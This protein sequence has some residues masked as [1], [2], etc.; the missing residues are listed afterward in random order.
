MDSLKTSSGSGRGRIEMNDKKSEKRLLLDPT[1]QDSVAL[2]KNLT[3]KKSYAALSCIISNKRMKTTDAYENL[4]GKERPVGILFYCLFLVLCPL[5][6]RYA[7]M[8]SVTKE[9]ATPKLKEVGNATLEMF[10]DWSCTPCTSVAG[11]T[12]SSLK[13]RAINVTSPNLEAGFPSIAIFASQD[14]KTWLKSHDFSQYFE[15]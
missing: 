8:A 3:G 15:Y 1:G 9:S 5:T 2:N 10:T 11:I 12:L 14:L 6:F 7:M 13:V 4:M